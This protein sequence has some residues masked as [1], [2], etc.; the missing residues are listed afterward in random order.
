MDTI[1]IY[2]FDLEHNQ[3]TYNP[4]FVV[5]T[6]SCTYLI[7]TK[8]TNMMSDALVLRKKQAALERTKAVNES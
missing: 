7:E 5:Q 6:D 4:D 1:Q 8:A 2:Y 3:R